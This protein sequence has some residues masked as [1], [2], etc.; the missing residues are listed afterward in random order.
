MSA[1]FVLSY[2]NGYPVATQ[3]C[4]PPAEALDIPP[5]EVTR[6]RR[7]NE[8]LVAALHSARYEIEHGFFLMSPRAATLARIDRAI[9]IAESLS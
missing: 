2:V 6:L 3:S 7:A 4:P 9:A 1:S 8:L 5:D